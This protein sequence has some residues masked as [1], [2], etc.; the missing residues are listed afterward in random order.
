MFALRGVVVSSSVFAMVYCLLSV[1]VM[2]AWRRIQVHAL[3]LPVGRA[4]NWLFRL[5]LLPLAGAAAV[6]SAFTV[7]SFLLLEPRSIYEPVHP[8]LVVFAIGGVGLGIYGLV[9]AAWALWRASRAISA[10]SLG[11]KPFRAANSLP[12]L[13]ISQAV[14]AMA[15]AGIL[16]PRVLVSRA[17]ERALSE[18]ELKA[19]LNHEMAHLRR[20]DNLKKLLLHT[21][22]FPGMRGL[23]AAWLEAIEMAAD[24]AAVSNP[25]E[26]LDLAAALIKLSRLTAADAAALDLTAAIVAG[27]MAIVRARIER[28][29]DWN[30]AR[31][32]A[33]GSS[34]LLWAY[35]ATVALMAGLTITYSHVLTR[36]HAAT[37]WLVR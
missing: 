18:S 8:G 29:M 21:V 34:R 15:A 33:Q 2:L 4:A 30:D 5:R 22:R 14:P 23:E 3:R 10:W 12:A 11:A 27:P 24:D 28:L 36:V 7:P 32:E 1:A 6:T 19:A 13:R 31:R 26:A 37:E 20:R 25:A 9:N 35:G 16:Y 17:A